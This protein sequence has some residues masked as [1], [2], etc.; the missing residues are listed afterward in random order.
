MCVDRETL[1]PVS[2][3]GVFTGG[4]YQ[5]YEQRLRR[6]VSSKPSHYPV[7]KD[8]YLVGMVNRHSLLKALA[9]AG[10]PEVTPSHAQQQT[11]EIEANATV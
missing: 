8:G 9:K 11:R 5:S 1:F 10:Q 6:A 3:T 2:D 7:V 4:S